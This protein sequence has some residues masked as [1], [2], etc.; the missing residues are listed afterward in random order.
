MKHGDIAKIT[1][2]KF[3]EQDGYYAIVGVNYSMSVGGGYKQ[4][5]DVGRFIGSAISD[6]NTFKLT[7]N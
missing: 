6:V 4:T 5:I 1:S 7:A 3:P 2:K